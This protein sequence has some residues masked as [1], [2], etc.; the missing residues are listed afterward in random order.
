VPGSL[1]EEIRIE[2]WGLTAALRRSDTGPLAL[3]VELTLVTTVLHLHLIKL[4]LIG[5]GIF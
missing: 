5:D 3:Y 2:S 1:E 4:I